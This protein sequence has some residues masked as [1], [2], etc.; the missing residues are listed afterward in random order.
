MEALAFLAVAELMTIPLTALICRH[1]LRC[2]RQVSYGTMVGG[3][4]CASLL[5]VIGTAFY[6]NGWDALTIDGWMYD[7]F[8]GTGA[9]FIVLGFITVVCVLPALG[10]VVYYQRRQKR[11]ESHVA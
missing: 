5:F 4:F 1:R 9:V 6:Y 8:F 10:V 7:K 2:K 3:A 11:D